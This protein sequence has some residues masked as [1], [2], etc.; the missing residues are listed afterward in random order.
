MLCF[1]C[2]WC[3]QECMS[4]L[5]T[6]ARVCVCVRH[7]SPRCCRQPAPVIHQLEEPI[8]RLR[9]EA[10]A[11]QQPWIS[12]YASDT[13]VHSGTAMAAAAEAPDCLYGTSCWPRRY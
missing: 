2:L 5:Y 9:N 10:A 11:S 8:S 1:G 7:P 3:V 13:V 6:H 4:G 12:R